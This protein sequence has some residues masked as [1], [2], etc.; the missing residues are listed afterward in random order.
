MVPKARPGVLKFRLLARSGQSPYFPNDETAAARQSVHADGIG[1]R[2]PRD[3]PRWRKSKHHDHLL[4]HGGGL[5]AALCHDHRA[6]NIRMP[7]F[8]DPGVR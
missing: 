3:D 8:G 2:G 7:R 1:T 4:D 5:Y 6:L